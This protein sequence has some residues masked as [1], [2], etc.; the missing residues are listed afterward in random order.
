MRPAAY[1]E[2]YAEADKAATGLGAGRGGVAGAVLVGRRAAWPSEH[3]LLGAVEAGLGACFFGLFD[4]EAAVLAALGVPEGWRAVGTDR[5]RPPRARRARS[6]PPAAAA[7][8]WPT[9]LHRNG[10]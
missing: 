8:P 4:H 2:R 1:V 6:A 9:S 3:L 10:W 5:P 7:C